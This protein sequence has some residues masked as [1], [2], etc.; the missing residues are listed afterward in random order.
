MDRSQH[1]STRQI[2]CWLREQLRR[3]GR[4]PIFQNS[5][6][7]LSWILKSSVR[8]ASM[9][10]QAKFRADRLNRCGDLAVFSIFSRWRRPVRHLGILKVEIF[11][12]STCSDG[13]CAS[14]CQIL[15]WSLGPLRRYAVFWLFKMAFFLKGSPKFRP[16]IAI[17]KTSVGSIYILKHDC[18]DA[19]CEHECGLDGRTV[20]RGRR[21]VGTGGKRY[22]QG[23]ADEGAGRQASRRPKSSQ[24]RLSLV[25]FN[26]WLRCYRIV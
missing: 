26:S 7:P 9:R 25:S 10:H 14:T 11:N 17:R 1:T 4:F 21:A 5:G 8:G 24:N 20:A 6:R 22:K 2:S 18:R 19:M 23:W 13:Q 15:C 12:W 3:Y 16:N